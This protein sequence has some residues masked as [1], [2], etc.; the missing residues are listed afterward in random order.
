MAQ[1]APGDYVAL[2]AYVTPDESLWRPLQEAR[3]RLRD[4]L[5]VATTL[6]YGPRYLHSTGQYHKGG[7]NKGHFIQLVGHDGRDVEIPGQAYTFGVLKRAQG[8]GDLAA[9]RAHDRRALRVCLGDDV[10]AGLSRFTELL[11][12]ALG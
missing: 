7:P 3:L 4:A 12:V 6:G 8:R 1:V 10:P 2:Q 11:T 9:L 5:R